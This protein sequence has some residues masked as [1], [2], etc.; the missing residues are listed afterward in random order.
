MLGVPPE[1]MHILPV[2]FAKPGRYPYQCTGA[3]QGKPGMKGVVVVKASSSSGGL[4][5]GS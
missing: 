5:G 3:G 2:T 1:N 4:Q